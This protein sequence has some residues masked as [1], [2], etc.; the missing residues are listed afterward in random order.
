[1]GRDTQLGIR[2]DLNFACFSFLLLCT[3]LFLTERADPFNHKF[4][5]ASSNY[6]GNGRNASDNN[7]LYLLVW[8]AI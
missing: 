6:D 3:M 8:A 1:M 5:G 7:T 2:R 4:D